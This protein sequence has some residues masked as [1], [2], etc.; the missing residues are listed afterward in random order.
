MKKLFYLFA[1]ALLLLAATWDP[2]DARENPYSYKDVF[3]DTGEDHPWGGGSELEPDGGTGL[4]ADGS[5]SIVISRVTLDMFFWKLFSPL[6]LERYSEPSMDYEIVPITE[7]GDS[8]QPIV[9][10]SNRSSK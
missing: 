10:E 4:T 8:D 7:P 6:I 2:A 5:S 1:V 9:R 3:R